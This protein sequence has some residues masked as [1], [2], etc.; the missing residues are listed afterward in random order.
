[1]SDGSLEDLAL[2]S[3][4]VMDELGVASSSNLAR[5]LLVLTTANVYQQFCQGNQRQ[6][7]SPNPPAEFEGMLHL[8]EVIFEVARLQGR[9]Y[10]EVLF[11]F[12]CWVRD[13]KG[14]K[15]WG[16]TFL[17]KYLAGEWAETAVIDSPESPE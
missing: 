12:L 11:E 9:P 2:D 7:Y 1:M 4:A 15:T 3:E 5:Q 16:W 8:V 13:H 17:G 14:R 10:S 6:P